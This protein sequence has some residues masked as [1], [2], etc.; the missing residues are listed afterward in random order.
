MTLT[1]IILL[2]SGI[3][4]QQISRHSKHKKHRITLQALVFLGIIYYVSTGSFFQQAWQANLSSQETRNV[5]MSMQN[6]EKLLA[7]IK[8]HC[9]QDDAKACYLAAGIYLQ[10]DQIKSSL[11]YA[12]KAYDHLPSTKHL[13]RLAITMIVNKKPFPKN[14]LDHLE[15]HAKKSPKSWIIIAENHLRNNQKSL[16][17][18]ALSN[19][20]TKATGED[21]EII[22]AQLNQ[23]GKH[24]QK[25]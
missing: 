25:I 10:Q 12:K 18:K 20:L 14:V 24:S 19:A 16:A 9:Q 3:I 7:S 23:L 11:Y 21:K 6:P 13:E 1:I 5:A 8:H 2:L 22:Q 17:R 4:C 15:K